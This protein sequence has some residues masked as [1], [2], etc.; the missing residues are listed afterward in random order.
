MEYSDYKRFRPLSC[1]VTVFMRLLG[2]NPVEI[3]S[4]PSP[5]PENANRKHQVLTPT[6]FSEAHITRAVPNVLIF[7]NQLASKLHLRISQP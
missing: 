7:I 6:M 4:V 2:R 5:K 3:P 1:L